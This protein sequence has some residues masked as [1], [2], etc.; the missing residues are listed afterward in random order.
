MLTAAKRVLIHAASA[1]TLC[2]GMTPPGDAQIPVP[3][4]AGIPRLQRTAQAVQLVVGGAP[5]LILGGEL[6][7]SSASSLQYMQPI[8]PR[9]QRTNLNTVLA[10][11]SWGELEEVE[12][13]FE[14][15]PWW[16]ASA[17]RRALTTSVWYC[18]GSGAG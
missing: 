4:P 15:S 9:L 16:T 8:W 17:A 18:Y 2:F 11:V 14:T 10:V 12:G 5:Y 13:R 3:A 1:A 6:H 7:N